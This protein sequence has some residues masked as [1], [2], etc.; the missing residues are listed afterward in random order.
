MISKRKRYVWITDPHI[1]IFGRYKLLNTILDQHPHGVFLT[2]DISEGPTFLSDLEFLGKRIGRPLYFVHGNHELWFSSFEKVHAGIRQLCVQYKNLIWMTDA[3]IV[4]L[5][6]RTALI[7]TEGWYDAGIGNP[8]Y[9]KY[10]FDWF[11]VKEFRQLPNMKARLELM[12][13]MAKKSAQTLALRLE[14]ALDGYKMV[15]V[16]TH[17]PSHAEAN[18]AK[19][20]FSEAFWAPYHINCSL[21]VELEKVMEKHKKRHMCVLSGHTHES[22]TVQIARN[23]ECR[24]GKGSYLHV[25]D[26]DLIY[27]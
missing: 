13:E 4:P 1:K 9:I 10:T 12:R 23:A 21:G 5:N 19:G 17:F 7:G 27:I 20:I 16:M 15:Y 6:E 11:L 8:E 22:M 2:G 24:V 18:R 26:K 14:E 25:S 3:G